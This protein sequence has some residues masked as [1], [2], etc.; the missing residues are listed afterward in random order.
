MQHL[1]GARDTSLV[2]PADLSQELG[3]QVC[4]RCHAS[5]RFATE[6]EYQGYRQRGNRFEPGKTLLEGG[7]QVNPLATTHEPYAFWKDGV[8]R[9]TSMEYNGLVQSPCYEK[10]TMTC[11]SCHD[12]HQNADDTRPAEEWRVDLLK[13]GMRGNEACV[14]CHPQ[15]IAEAQL[16]AHTNHAADSRGSQCM[17]CHMPHTSIGLR[18]A[19]R[20]HQVTN[21][22]PSNDRSSGRLNA[23][24]ACHLDKPLEWAAAR[25]EAW[26]GIPAGEFDETD[27]TVA[28]GVVNALRGDAAQRA[29]TGWH[30]GWGPAR[31]AAN[32]E[33]WGPM[34]LAELIADPYESVR[35]IARRSLRAMPE[36]ADFEYDFVSPAAVRAAKAQEVAQQWLRKGPRDARGDAARRGG[37]APGGCAA[38]GARR[39]DR[40]HPRLIGAQD[41]PW[42]TR[43]Q[44]SS[45]TARISASALLPCT[46]PGVSV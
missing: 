29:V 5:Q 35:F 14:G 11:F 13:P 40:A 10:G 28:V 19:S 7:I 9:A 42:A 31:E 43:P 4:G 45:P 6:D 22:D 39:L 2:V 34:L 1:F 25:V 15:F 8:A 20:S 23:C 36:F 33:T 37:S 46:T 17:D 3:S 30:L 32:T 18:K 26:Y 27:R 12:L 21:P 44:T 24:S 41:P 16:A 38:R